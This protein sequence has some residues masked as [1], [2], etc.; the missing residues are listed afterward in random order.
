MKVFA[1]ISQEIN[2]DYYS[3]SLHANLASAEKR[4]EQLVEE[5]DKASKRNGLELYKK[6]DPT[7]WFNGDI[8]ISI[9][10]EEVEGSN[11]NNYY[12][13]PWDREF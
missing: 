5:A 7:C 3:F 6:E 2:G 12:G 10:V 1:V 4:V 9:E 11:K 13:I 8:Q